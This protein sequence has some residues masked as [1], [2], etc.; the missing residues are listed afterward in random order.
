MRKDCFTKQYKTELVFV[1]NE[2]FACFGIETTVFRITYVN[3]GL[4]I[5]NIE[6]RTGMGA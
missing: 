4:C 5:R 2:R 1:M 6:R 3:I